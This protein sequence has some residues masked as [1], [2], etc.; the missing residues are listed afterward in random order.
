MNRMQR[1]KI[2]WPRFSGSEMADLS[3]YLHGFE[4]KRRKS[5]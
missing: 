4:L 1:Q 3:A 2:A 5:P